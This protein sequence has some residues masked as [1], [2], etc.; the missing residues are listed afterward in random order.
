MAPC[1][2]LTLL[3]QETRAED[4][5]ASPSTSA[6]LCFLCCRGWCVQ[7]FLSNSHH[8]LGAFKMQ[9]NTATQHT[10]LN[11]GTKPHQPN[12]LVITPSSGKSRIGSRDLGTNSWLSFPTIWLTTTYHYNRGSGGG[13]QLRD[14]CQRF[15]YHPKLEAPTRRRPQDCLPRGMNHSE[16]HTPTVIA[17]KTQCHPVRDKS[18]LLTNN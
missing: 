18:N 6:Y 7:P 3:A 4:L 12:A 11:A 16:V 10:D 15:Q 1:P 13:A 17:R 8:K 14:L 2:H 5:V 9:I